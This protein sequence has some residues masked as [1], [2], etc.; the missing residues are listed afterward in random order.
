[1]P[2]NSETIEELYSYLFAVRISL[3]DSYE[4]ESD[5]IRE[6]KNYL[7]D[8]GENPHTINQTL[9]G[10]YQHYGIDISLSIIE[11][12][13]V[14]NNQILNNM[15][16]FMLSSADFDNFGEESDGEQE[17]NYGE[18]E[19]NDGE[20]E[21]ND[22]EQDEGESNESSEVNHQNN[23][24]VNP[25]IG[26][27][28]FSNPFFTIQLSSNGQT[29]TFNSQSGSSFGPGSISNFASIFGDSG[30]NSANGANGA[31]GP[32]FS[33]ISN[34]QGPTGP[35]SGSAHT[36]THSN[37]INL[38]NS[39]LNGLGGHGHIGTMGANAFQD[40]VVTVD[41]KDLE[42]LKSNKLDANLET[43]CSVCMGHMEKDEMVTELK[44]THTFHTDCIEPYLKQY[45]YK[46][47]VCR[48]EVGK[49]KY[50]I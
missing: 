11:Q 7:L 36:H 21:E 50:N 29:Y 44:C 26:P 37:M 35:S 33:N 34:L 3:Q 10:F 40:V 23:E 12:V 4:S 31:N 42:K 41:D 46:C 48:A 25:N 14:I 5:I 28:G 27:T 49:T 32:A 15:L 47:P 30:V 16:G 2:Q 1:M 22:G 8:T 39:L 24:H 20:Q 6:L 45:N 9:H 13:P 19:E 18:Q 17:E 43:D 38:L